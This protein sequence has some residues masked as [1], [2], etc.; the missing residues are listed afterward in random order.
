MLC[1]CLPSRAFCPLESLL[2][3]Q[4]F[5]PDSI[6]GFVCNVQSLYLF[7][8]ITVA[9]YHKH[10]GLRQCIISQFCPTQLVYCC[11]PHKAKGKVSV[12]GQWKWQTYWEAQKG[13]ASG[14]RP[15][16][17]RVQFHVVLGQKSPCPCRLT[18]G[19]ASLA[20][21]SCPVFPFYLLLL[22]VKL[23]GIARRPANP[24]SSP[25]AEVFK[26]S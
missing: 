22:F 6:L 24:A 12:D 4:H 8:I 3:P 9:N 14:C 7:S 16:V 11:G 2:Y 20:Q 25:R 17:G 18:A 15:V 1:V 21:A 10:T 13:C 19:S 5:R 26:A 23:E